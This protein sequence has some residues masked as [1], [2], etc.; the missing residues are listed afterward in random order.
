MRPTGVIADVRAKPSL[1]PA[2]ALCVVYG[3]S[4]TC[5]PSPP[6]SAAQLLPAW[7]ADA[8]SFTVSGSSAKLLDDAGHVVAEL[9]RTSKAVGNAQA[10]PAGPYPPTPDAKLTARLSTPA[11]LPDGVQL[12]TGADLVGRWIPAKRGANP[13]AYL[14]FAANG[15]WQSYDGCNEDDGR[16]RDS[17][18]HIV[19]LGGA[20][21]GVGCDN[22]TDLTEPLQKAVEVGTTTSGTLEFFDPSGAGLVELARAPAPAAPSTGN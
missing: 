21:A 13:K 12:V 16:W 17:D 6:T 3:V 9:S 20:V 8:A 5:L 1:A 11:A 2:A 14:V 19:A 7:L 22:M 10:M 4:G 18:G 15:T